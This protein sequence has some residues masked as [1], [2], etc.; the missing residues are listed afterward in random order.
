VNR[1]ESR[2]PWCGA[3][4]TGPGDLEPGSLVDLDP[5]GLDPGSLVDLDPG[6]L[7][8][9]DLDLDPGDL[10]L[11]PGDLDPGGGGG[12][13]DPGGGDQGDDQGDDQGTGDPESRAMGQ[14]PRGRF[15]SAKSTTYGPGA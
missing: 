6:V 8:P 1:G 4:P 13:L 14:G 11:D 7:D 2:A 15:R 12:G 9:G 5:G 10:D 3:K